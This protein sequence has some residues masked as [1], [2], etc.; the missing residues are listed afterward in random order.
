MNNNNERGFVLSKR[1]SLLAH[2]IFILTIIGTIIYSFV[3]PKFGLHW[4][5]IVIVILPIWALIM[6]SISA[7]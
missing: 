2:I 4:G 6:A 1:A 5:W 3:V 7:G